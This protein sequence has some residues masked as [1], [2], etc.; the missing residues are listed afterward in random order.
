MCM[1]DGWL[2]LV[3]FLLSLRSPV[4]A[5]RAP[6][7]VVGGPVWTGHRCTG[8]LLQQARLLEGVMGCF[9]VMFMGIYS[10]TAPA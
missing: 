8:N 3:C 4:H 1:A 5:C 6:G 2:L 10:A 9:P 7:P